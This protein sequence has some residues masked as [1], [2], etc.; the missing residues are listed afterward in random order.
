MTIFQPKDEEV[1]KKNDVVASCLE[2][3]HSTEFRG[4]VREKEQKISLI[5]NK[6]SDLIKF[7]TRGKGWGN[8]PLNPNCWIEVADGKTFVPKANAISEGVSDET[9]YNRRPWGGKYRNDV[10]RLWGKCAVTGCKTK[11]LLTASHIKAVIYCENHDEKIDPYNSILL[12]K[13]YDALFDRGL[14]T[15]RD[16]GTIVVS[17]KI[18]RSDLEAVGV[19]LTAKIH[20]HPQ[21][22]PYLKFHREEIFKIDEHTHY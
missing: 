16:D 15:F 4:N 21:Q 13:V 14:I 17:K 5:K 7:Q 3:I 11:C 8:S 19:K 22:L 2:Y 12:S 20:L 10:L 6:N 18:P 9:L 1:F